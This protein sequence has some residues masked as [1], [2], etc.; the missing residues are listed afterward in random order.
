M[1]L[2]LLKAPPA[3]FV[4][5]AWQG[6]RI[7]AMASLL[8]RRRTAPTRW[9]RPSGA[10]RPG[11]RPAW[12]LPYTQVQSY[13]D[14]GEPRATTTT[15]RPNTWPS[16][17]TAC[18]RPPARCSPNAPCRTARWLPPAR[19]ALNERDADD[20][21]VG[22]RDTRFAVGVKGRWQA[23]GADTPRVPEV[24]PRRRGAAAAL[25]HRAHLHQLPDRRRGRGPRPGDLR[26][27][28]RLVGPGQAAYDPDN[29]FRSNRNIR[30]EA[31][32]AVPSA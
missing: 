15:G 9:P 22:N 29:L 19:R 20:G 26:R 16:S 13:L 4:P 2:V 21:A 28:L 10:G 7:V 11:V 27:Q 18:C 32:E 6:R 24:G 17:T 30:P 8:Q 25:L 23:D 31:R 14:D 5:P 3:P 12:E 1:F